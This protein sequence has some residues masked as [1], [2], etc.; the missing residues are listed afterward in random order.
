MTESIK[1]VPKDC[2]IHHG[3]TGGKCHK[4]EYFNS[5]HYRELKYRGLQYRGDPWWAI[6]GEPVERGNTR[7]VS[8]S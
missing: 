2:G 7:K 3:L 6:L 4:C 5:E 8:S 1:S